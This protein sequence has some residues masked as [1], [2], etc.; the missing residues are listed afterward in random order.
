MTWSDHLLVGRRAAM[1]LPRFTRLRI[2]QCE[3]VATSLKQFSLIFLLLQ[4]LTHDILLWTFVPVQTE[5][6][7]V[8]M[9]RNHTSTHP[10]NVTNSASWLPP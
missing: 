1:R 8:P 5:E 7:Y 9:C 10:R 3:H 2:A 6:E 4:P